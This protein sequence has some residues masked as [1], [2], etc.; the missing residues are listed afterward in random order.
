VESE[1]GCTQIIRKGA[2]HAAMPRL[3]EFQMRHGARLTLAE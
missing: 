2:V 3:F 1:L